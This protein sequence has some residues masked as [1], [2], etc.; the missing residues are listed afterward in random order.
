[1]VTF[2]LSKRNLLSG[3]ALLFVF[4]ALVAVASPSSASFEDRVFRV[5]RVTGAGFPADLPGTP[6]I[7]EWVFL[8][9][10]YPV[11]P[12]TEGA[13]FTFEGWVSDL[14]FGHVVWSFV[15]GIVVG[16]I[17]VPARG[18]AGTLTLEAAIE[19]PVRSYTFRF[20]FVPP[21]DYIGFKVKAIVAVERLGYFDSEYGRGSLTVEITDSTT[22]HLLEAGAI[23]LSFDAYSQPWRT[24]LLGL[25]LGETG[26]AIFEQA[27][28]AWGVL[29]DNT[30]R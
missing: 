5:D 13:P 2:R 28:A 11:A 15:D 3:G 23:S 8:N 12:E 9:E 25:F 7:G 22:R 30:S 27:F 16:Q 4:A 24:P 21:D 29:P 18:I 17:E 26:Q 20:D 19:D 10:D 6:A 1:M 14:S